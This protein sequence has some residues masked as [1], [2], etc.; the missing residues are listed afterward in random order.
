MKESALGVPHELIEEH[1]AVSEAVACAMAEGCR[2]VC[3]S[4]IAVSVTGVAG[5]E[6]DERD[7]PVGTVF[8]GLAT[9]H[10]TICRQIDLS[11]GRSRGH[12]RT[13]AAHHAFDIVRR[14]LLHTVL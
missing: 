2:R 7:H 5:P 9:K 4:D 10:G 11:R 14:S 3:G 13:L 1:G 12:I 8:I 6:R